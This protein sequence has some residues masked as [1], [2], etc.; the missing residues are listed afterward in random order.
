MKNRLFHVGTMRKT[1][2]LTAL[3]VAATCVVMAEEF[4]YETPTINDWRPLRFTEGENNFNDGDVIGV[5][6]YHIDGVGSPCAA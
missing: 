4:T 2:L 5:D 1:A 3:V 6:G